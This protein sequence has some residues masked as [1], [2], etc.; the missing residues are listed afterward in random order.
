MLNVFLLTVLSYALVVFAAV[1][2]FGERFGFVIYNPNPRLKYNFSNWQGRHI[3]CALVWG[4]YAFFFMLAGAQFLL[5]RNKDLFYL[6]LG[7]VLLVTYATI[8]LSVE[9]FRLVHAYAKYSA[10]IKLAVVASAVFIG[11]KASA[12]T[13]STIANYTSVNASNFPDAQKIITIF[14]TIGIWLY[15]AVVCSLGIYAAISTFA[16]FKM[17]TSDRASVK[18]DRY[19]RCLYGSAPIGGD[20]SKKELFMVATI[21]LGVAMVVVSPINYVKK[22]KGEDLDRIA[23]DLLV[24]TS[25]HLDPIICGIKA[26]DKSLMSLLPFQQA[27]V[28]IP[29][30]KSIYRFTVIKC[31]RKF[32]E[33]P[34]DPNEMAKT[35]EATAQ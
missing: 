4:G 34:A 1:M 12:V 22:I 10:V 25:F 8:A 18:A 30:S 23:K 26:P 20:S 3:N 7:P 2:V 31:N 11:Y 13:D 6:T 15:S 5:F 14:V 9:Y 24:E 35:V 21:I 27:I 32:E 28:A 19:R 17:I 16:I 33:L 29:D